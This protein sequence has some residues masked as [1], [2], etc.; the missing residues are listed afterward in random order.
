MRVCCV[1]LTAIFSDEDGDRGCQEARHLPV[2]LS[3]RV[4]PAGRGLRAGIAS[5]LTNHLTFSFHFLLGGGGGVG[6]MSKGALLSVVFGQGTL[7]VCQVF[8]SSL[9][10]TSY[11]LV[12]IQMSTALN[13]I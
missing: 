2:K 3:P 7:A 9:L 12:L 5:P 1:Q 8:I 10:V 11:E 13:C 4:A 6:A